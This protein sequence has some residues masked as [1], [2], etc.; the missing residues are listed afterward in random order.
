MKT[1]TDDH[2]DSGGL[3]KFGNGRLEKI[4]VGMVCQQDADLIGLSHRAQT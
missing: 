3:L 1:S 4:T 2:L